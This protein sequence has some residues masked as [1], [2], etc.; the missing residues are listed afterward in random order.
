MKLSIGYNRIVG[1]TMK[2]GEQL[3]AI[4][5]FTRADLFSGI[6]FR[7]P[8]NALIYVFWRCCRGHWRRAA[9]F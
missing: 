6:N 7:W 2:R 9:D 1:N 4:W 5:L 8:C 3:D